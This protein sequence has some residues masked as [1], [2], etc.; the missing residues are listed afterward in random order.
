MGNGGK[1]TT[2]LV[3]IEPGK[4]ARLLVHYN[5]GEAGREKPC[6]TYGKVRITSSGIT[7]GLVL[8]ESLQLCGG[9]EVHP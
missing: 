2:Q 7:R 3:T 9:L 4:S 6:P 1:T 8:R 5:A